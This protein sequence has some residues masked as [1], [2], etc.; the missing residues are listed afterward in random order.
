MTS[1]FVGDQRPPEN[2]EPDPAL[3]GFPP[4]QPYAAPPPRPP[5][6]PA[7]LSAPPPGMPRPDA[8]A[9]GVRAP[10]GYA[11]AR[12]AYPAAPAATR[13]RP[14]VPAGVRDADGAHLHRARAGQ[15]AAH[16][17]GALPPDA[18]R[19]AVPLVE[20][21]RH[22]AARPGHRHP[23][24]DAVVRAAGGDGAGHRSRGPR[25]VRAGRQRPVAHRVR[26]GQP[27]PDRADPVVRPDDLDRAPD[28]AALRVLGGRRHPL[29]LAGSAARSSCCRCG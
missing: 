20:A 14:T 23:A 17:A 28:P 1:P 15:C 13:R 26:G 10:P 16:R 27:Q 25:P 8:A 4:P 9:A 24:A 11:A 18:A 5:S 6:Y 29:A 12:T 2:P 7:G 22:P 21:D 3:A 19:T